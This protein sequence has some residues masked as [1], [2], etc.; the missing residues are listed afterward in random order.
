MD[1]THRYGQSSPNRSRG[2]LRHLQR[3]RNERERVGKGNGCLGRASSLF[4][5]NS[6]RYYLYTSLLLVL[7]PPKSSESTASIVRLVHMKSEILRKVPGCSALLNGFSSCNRG[8][9][10]AMHEP[11]TKEQQGEWQGQSDQPT[12]LHSAHFHSPPAYSML[13]AGCPRCLEQV[14]DVKDGRA[15]NVA[16]W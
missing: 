7:S 9:A 8:L 5:T 12:C 6:T 14:P 16:R 13:P 3:T 2:H 1:R 4:F 10:W 11:R 15:L